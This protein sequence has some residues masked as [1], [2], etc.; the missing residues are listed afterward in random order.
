MDNE[1]MKAYAE[2]DKILSF[3]ESKYV[4]KVPK[5]LR[6][7]F[8]NEKLNDYNPTINKNIP[9]NEQDLER[10]TYAILAMLDLNYWCDDE[11]EKQELLRAYSNNDKKHQEELR[12][13]YNPDNMFKN[14]TKETKEE[15]VTALVEYKEASFIKRLIDRIKRLFKR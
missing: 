2:V 5:K 10:K 14:R 4:K 11:E 13:K 8:K 6:E 1:L 7:I 9:L 12:E 15:K 3:M